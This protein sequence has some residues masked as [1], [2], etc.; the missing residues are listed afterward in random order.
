MKI[1]KTSDDEGYIEVTHEEYLEQLAEGLSYEE[2]LRPGRH[3]FVRGG[4]RKLHP[5]F[6][7]ARATVQYTIT[8]SFPPEVYNYFKQQTPQGDAKS[9]AEVME[10]ILLEVAAH[11]QIESP[12]EPIVK[13]ELLEDPR[14]I[15]AVAER[16]KKL[17][18]PSKP[19]TKSSVKP[20]TKSNPSKPRRRVA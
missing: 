20:R 12:A 10:K 1:E 13:Q 19:S 3:K 16:V 4:F 11:A 17:S 2:V 15:K 14:F 5:D 8:L 7:P 6:D 9:T 18:K